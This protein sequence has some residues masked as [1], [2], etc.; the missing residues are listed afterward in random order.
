MGLCL[1]GGPT[2]E[3]HNSLKLLVIEEVVKRP[4]R[5][6]FSKRVRREIWIVT[7]DITVSESNF[8]VNSRPE[9]LLEAAKYIFSCRV[10]LTIHHIQNP[11]KRNKADLITY[12]NPFRFQT[13]GLRYKQ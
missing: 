6:L 1:P 9:I 4:E 12:L 5:A 3:K 7:V 2:S 10:K 13:N 11:L 8:L